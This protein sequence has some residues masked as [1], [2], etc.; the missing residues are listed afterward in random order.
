MDLPQVRLVRLACGRV[1]IEAVDDMFGSNVKLIGSWPEDL[2]VIMLFEGHTRRCGRC[3]RNPLYDSASVASCATAP[4][5][6][7]RVRIK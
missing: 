5:L 3:F 7:Q 4:V 6:L 1:V 2:A